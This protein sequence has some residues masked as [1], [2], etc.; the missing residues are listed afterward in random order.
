VL[1]GRFAQV[2]EALSLTLMVIGAICLCQPVNKAI[3]TN[4][5]PLLFI[6]FIGLNIFSHRKPV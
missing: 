4:G 5:F 6:G 2:A 3:F 1:K